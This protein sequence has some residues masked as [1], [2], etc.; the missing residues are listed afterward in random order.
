MLEFRP[1]LAAMAIFIRR[2]SFHESLTGTVRKVSS[3]FPSTIPTAQVDGRGQR[4]EE[5]V[6]GCAS[7]STEL[8]PS[9]RQAVEIA[10][11]RHFKS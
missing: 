7:G 8:T 9:P 6:S 3:G 4:P 11:Q 10:I 1:E 5:Y 2:H